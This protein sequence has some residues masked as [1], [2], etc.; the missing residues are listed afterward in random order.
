MIY[1]KCSIGKAQI[2]IS[3]QKFR[4]WSILNG[5][6]SSPMLSPRKPEEKGKDMPVINLDKK[7]VLQF[8]TGDIALAPSNDEADVV[9]DTPDYIA[10]WQTENKKIGINPEAG[11]KGDKVDDWALKMYIPNKE[12][13]DV[14]MRVFNAYGLQK[15]GEGL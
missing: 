8:G 2:E 13:F 11:E 4:L 12:S 10:F 6:T 9:P 7:M 5:V 1:N 15:F 3:V 14:I